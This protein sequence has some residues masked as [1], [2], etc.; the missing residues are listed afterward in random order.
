LLFLRLSLVM[1]VLAWADFDLICFERLLVRQAER[2]RLSRFYFVGLLIWASFIWARYHAFVGRYGATLLLEG[3]FA[4][5]LNFLL[6]SLLS[7]R[8]SLF[9]NLHFRASLGL[10]HGVNWLLWLDI[11]TILLRCSIYILQ[12]LLL[13]LICDPML[14]SR[15]NTTGNTLTSKTS[16][17]LVSDY[18]NEC[19]RLFLSHVL[20]RCL[21]F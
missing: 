10:F 12:T 1:H 17:L 5:L 20:F 15:V 4:L 14:H 18:A 2:L 7:W 16:L 11:H 19:S 6:H 21:G 13:M 8:T 9:K 3:P